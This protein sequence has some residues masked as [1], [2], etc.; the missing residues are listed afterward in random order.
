M[1]V[2]EALYYMP[3]N[4]AAA[5]FTLVAAA[6]LGRI[7]RHSTCTRERASRIARLQVQVNL[8][9]TYQQ[10]TY[11]CLHPHLHPPSHPPPSFIIPYRNIALLVPFLICILTFAWLPLLNCTNPRYLHTYPTHPV[12]IQHPRDP[13]L[14]SGHSRSA[15]E[16]LGRS[17]DHPSRSPRLSRW[18][19]STTKM[20]SARRKSA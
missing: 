12:L 1:K 10:C 6:G 9:N 19:S 3:P 2:G 5:E 18:S 8:I 17:R 14:L 4:D 13:S 15:V 20:F 16:E 11:I 7:F